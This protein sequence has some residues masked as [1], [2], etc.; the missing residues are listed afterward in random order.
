M[1]TNLNGKHLT[2]EQ[3]KAILTAMKA[4]VRVDA[5][6]DHRITLDKG[7][8]VFS[9]FAYDDGFGVS[10]RGNLREEYRTLNDFAA[11]YGL[12]PARRA[13]GAQ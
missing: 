9:R 10:W 1:D 2:P 3:A 4:L 13:K 12:K 8:L 11:A 6:L 5:K 7:D